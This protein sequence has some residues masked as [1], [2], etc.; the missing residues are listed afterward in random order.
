MIDCSHANS[1]K[2]PAR[3]PSVFQELV[4]QSITDKSVIGAMIEGNINAGNQSFPQAVEDLK[5]GVSITDGC[6]AWDTT[7]EAIRQAYNDLAPL[8]S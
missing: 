8:F 4:R 5:Y 6:I 1:G 3:Q 7:E 2:D